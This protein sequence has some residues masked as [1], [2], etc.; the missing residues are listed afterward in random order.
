MLKG[1]KKR[2]KESH[3]SNFQEDEIQNISARKGRVRFSSRVIVH[4]GP[5]LHCLEEDTQ[6]F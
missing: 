6:S 3:E 2:L 1:L 5:L 4:V